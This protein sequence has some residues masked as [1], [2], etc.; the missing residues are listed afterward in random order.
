MIAPILSFIR[1]GQFDQAYE[2]TSQLLQ[3]DP[4]NAQF[5]HALGVLQ[6][7]RCEWAPA[8]IS[9]RRA[10]QHQPG[11]ADWWRDLGVALIASGVP[12][13]AVE[14]LW[15]SLELAVTADTLTYYGKAL[16]SLGRWTEAVEAHRRSID[17][18]RRS[19]NSY[20][21]LAA[22]YRDRRFYDRSYWY[23]T[24]AAKLKRFDERSLYI[25]ACSYFQVGNLR[26]ALRTYR[27]AIKGIN[28]DCYSGYLM[29][30]VHDSKQTPQSLRRAHEQWFVLHGGRPADSVTFAND[31]DPNRRLRIGYISADFRAAPAQYFLLPVL[32]AHDHSKFNIHCY[33]LTDL[34]DSIT[35]RYK[36]A[37]NCWRQPGNIEE[38]RRLVLEDNID[39]LIDVSGHF[40]PH[41]LAALHQRSAPVQV[42]YLNYPCTTGCKEIDFFLTDSWITPE[43][44]AFEQQYSERAVYRVPKGCLV[45]APP[46][47][48]I[49]VTALPAL[50][51]GYVTFGL[52]QRPAKFNDDLWDTVAEIL[53]TLPES[54]LLVH[55]A[56]RDLEEPV[57]VTRNQIVNALAGRGIDASRLDFVGFKDVR[58]DLEVISRVDI[59]LDTFPYSGHTTTCSSLWMGVPVVSLPGA[60]HASRVSY[61]FLARLGLSDW[62][63]TSTEAYV[64]IATSKARDW[65]ALSR[66][67]A[68]L[69]TQMEASINQPDIVVREIEA[70]FR[71]MWR[72]WC[73]S[74]LQSRTTV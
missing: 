27:R 66:L 28:S 51:N 39:I 70:G 53:R 61:S 60:T 42:T 34:Q 38:L 47:D 43:A 17:L 56:N 63:G 52:F 46:V 25:L 45:Y 54:R 14:P 55:H 8:Q 2:V 69:R 12:D 11:Q 62:A 36:N 21:S 31:C 18:D 29:A 10:I 64:K 4:E 72:Q 73:S 5:L 68:C 58:G 44:K 65:A 3:A 19:V 71:L 50:S 20:E 15:R 1:A 23:A 59:A 41:G 9:L 74:K 32:S 30:L 7:N 6:A 16:E 26:S 33:S 37:T 40:A 49:E 48:T 57:S 67:R 13:Q 24:R 22:L 35:E